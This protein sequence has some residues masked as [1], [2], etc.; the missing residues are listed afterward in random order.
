MNHPDNVFATATQAGWSRASMER[1]EVIPFHRGPRS[2]PSV[3]RRGPVGRHNS[4][5]RFSEYCHD[6]WIDFILDRTKAQGHQAEFRIAPHNSPP[7]LFWLQPPSTETIDIPD[8]SPWP[9]LEVYRATKCPWSFRASVSPTSA[10]AAA[11][12]LSSSLRLSAASLVEC[13]LPQPVSVWT[14]TTTI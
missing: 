11:N 3:W 2:R 13:R 6:R 10:M 4:A 8:I 5:V 1:T 9:A 12:R 7:C 14:R